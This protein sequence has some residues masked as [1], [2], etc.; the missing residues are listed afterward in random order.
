MVWGH[1]DPFL[2]DGLEKT[3][4]LTARTHH[5]WSALHSSGTTNSYAEVVCGGLLEFVCLLRLIQNLFM[6]MFILCSN[7]PSAQF[8]LF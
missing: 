6:L 8:L 3:R 2:L 5:S 1:L 7:N 4:E